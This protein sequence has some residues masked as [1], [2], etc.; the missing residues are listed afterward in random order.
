MQPAYRVGRD[1]S[2]T[3]PRRREQV[4][5]R[6]VFT[7]MTITGR[8]SKFEVGVLCMQVLSLKKAK[9]LITLLSREIIHVSTIY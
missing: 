3:Q 2:A 6:I 7:I 9:D 1:A 8:M 4:M 5:I